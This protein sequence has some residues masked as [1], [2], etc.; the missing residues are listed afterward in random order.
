MDMNTNVL[1]SDNATLLVSLAQ[2]EESKYNVRH[3]T[4]LTGIEAL[5]AN[6]LACGLN[7]NLVVHQ[8]SAG[9]KSA[10]RYGVVAGRRRL[11]AL[12]WLADSG[13]IPADYP[14][15]VKV[16]EVDSARLVSLSENEQ[17]EAM[18]PY[19]QIM[20]FS[21]LADEGKSP[22]FIASVFGLS[23]LT[24]QRRLKLAR[25]A[26][27][28][29]ALL[30]SDEISLEQL[31]A[32]A[33]SDDH[34][35]QRQLWQSL[36]TW[37]RSASAIRMAITEEEIDASRH[38]L[39][40]FVGMD[41]YE[42]AGGR[43]R[44]DLF[45]DRTAGYLLDADLLWQ[46]AD[47]KLHSS[48]EALQADGWQ[49]VE[50]YPDGFDYEA[51]SQFVMMERPVREATDSEQLQLDVLETR[52]QELSEA[53]GAFD[54]ACDESDE[55]QTALEAIEA[56]MEDICEARIADFD[57]GHGGCALEVDSQGH[58]AI[59]EGL[60]RKSDVKNTAPA[61][62]DANGKSL[63]VKARPTHSDKLVR[64]LAA[65]QTVA[66]QAEMIKQP[67]AAL[68]ILIHRLLCEA[69]S[70]YRHASQCLGICVKSP[71]RELHQAD[72]SL[73]LS[74]AGQRMADARSTWQAKLPAD[75][76]ER[77]DWLAAWS[78]D[79]Q[80]ALLAYLSAAQLNA[81]QQD[82]KQRPVSVLA[83]YLGLDMQEYWQP[84][85]DRYLKHVSKDRIVALVSETISPEAALPLTGLKKAEAI[86]RAE[87]LLLPIGWLPPLMQHSA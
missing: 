76:T 42:A 1:A 85:A 32:L 14:V 35:Q 60:Q 33:L 73:P 49:W 6:I 69:E 34:E 56:E 53:L 24:V 64:R 18:H 54:E 8:I 15:P 13:Q 28:L 52:Y 44:R 38:R 43:V 63:S 48:A 82:E 2:L 70:Q 21:A 25:V 78:L 26:P 19:Q 3:N 31:G 81:M 12:R 87:A 77:L 59:H 80:L 5:A 57:K 71:Q 40:R 16:I 72:D 4:P 47:A 58:I 86:G 66:M 46:L 30:L 10:P 55:I 75:Y 79:E 7:Q 9:K 62:S 50:I 51:R 68:V 23:A 45:D 61:Q 36:P 83:Q 84:D 27:D 37:Q 11:A 67:A 39:A 17:R 65:Q 41:A 29:L 74:Y 22:E 20:A